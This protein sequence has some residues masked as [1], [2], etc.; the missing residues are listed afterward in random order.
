ML[1]TDGSGFS[2]PALPWEARLTRIYQ[3]NAHGGLSTSQRSG[4]YSGSYG[5]EAS[6]DLESAL[7]LVDSTA[8]VLLEGARPRAGSID[9]T[10]VGSHFG[11]NGDAM[12]GEWIDGAELWRL[13]SFADDRL[14]VPVGKADLTAGI[15]YRD[16]ISGFDL[17][18]CANDENSQF[19]GGG[20][21]IGLRARILIG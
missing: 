18:A 6:A 16:V 1:R 17:N 4:R 9:P 3:Q 20:L 8:Y 11:V 5:V 12:E 10:L 15:E 21:M 7:G 14:F 19:L 13:R 2:N